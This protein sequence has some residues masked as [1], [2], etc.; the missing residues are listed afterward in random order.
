MVRALFTIVEQNNSDKE[1]VY[2]HRP[3]AISE[4]SIVQKQFLICQACFWCA[5]YYTYDTT[6]WF[7]KFNLAAILQCPGCSAKS[8]VESLPILQN[9]HNG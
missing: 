4:C 8:T 1:R 9:E 5:S 2:E 3:S 6:N 7:P